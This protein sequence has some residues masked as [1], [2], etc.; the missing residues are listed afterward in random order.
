MKKYEIN[1]FSSTTAAISAIILIV[2]ASDL[3]IRLLNKLTELQATLI[4]F[5][6]LAFAYLGVRFLSKGKIVIELTETSFKHK[7]IKKCLFDRAIDIELE[8]DDILNYGGGSWRLHEYFQFDLSQ[9]RKYRIFR[10]SI[11]SSKDDFQKFKDE[12]PQYFRRIKKLKEINH[13]E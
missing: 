3:S 11:F 5:P 8:W 7:W 9:N 12:L 4:I 2:I 1:I 6:L 10:W 13:E